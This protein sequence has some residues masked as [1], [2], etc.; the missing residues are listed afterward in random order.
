VFVQTC[1]FGLGAETGQLV[2]ASVRP[3]ANMRTSTREGGC[4]LAG[5]VGTILRR[6]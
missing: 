1:D 6:C 5:P 2:V 4:D 3:P